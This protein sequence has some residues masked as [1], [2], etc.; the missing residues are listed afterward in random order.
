MNAMDVLSVNQ[1]EHIINDINSN[2]LEE[3]NDSSN[4]N[5]QR[6]NLV[7]LLYYFFVDLTDNN[8]IN[9]KLP[10]KILSV[11]LADKGFTDIKSRTDSF[12]SDEIFIQEAIELMNPGS[13][14]PARVK[15]DIDM[16]EK[17]V[18]EM[19]NKA[20]TNF[21][22]KESVNKDV[23]G[24]FEPAEKIPDLEKLPDVKSI[25]E[26]ETSMPK[27]EPK[28]LV[29]NEEIYSNDLIFE[30]QFSS[31]IP[32][33]PSSGKEMREIL[34]YE[35]FCEESYRKK[36]IK[37]LFHKNELSFKQTVSNILDLTSWNE[38]IPVLEKI[39]TKN[40]TDLYSEETV[41]F[42]DILQGH[43]TK[44]TVY[45]SQKQQGT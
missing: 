30:A 9:I 15:S 29:I 10:K 25:R 45:S 16:S 17:T 13:K 36:I 32:Q 44:T 19:V 37:K 5:S 18:K 23:E 39:F 43:F 28:T 27:V 1:I 35:L 6:L 3:I 22:N 2:L 20:K 4:G 31:I 7:K 42:V 34:I 8:P 41:K 21:I 40:K 11:F 26:T 33:E 24:I 12:F 14:K 38:V